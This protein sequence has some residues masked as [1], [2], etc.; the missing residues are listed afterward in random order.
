[1]ELRVLK[2]FLAVA[3][4]ESFTRAAAVLHIS[5]PTLSRQIQA[6]ED[7]L[8]K[9]LLTRTTQHLSL[10]SDGILLRKRA[11]EILALVE[12]AESEIR[13]DYEQIAG[14]IYIGG[15]ESTIFLD[16]LEVAR[17]TQEEFPFIHFHTVT[18]DC[19]MTLYDM[20]K[21]LIDF[22][23]VYGDID[24]AKYEKITLT[25]HDNWGIIMRSDDPLAAK[26]S[27]K[28]EDLYDKQLI[29][30]R[31]ALSCAAH[32]DDLRKWF[33]C[34]ME[35]LRIQ[36]SFTMLF[37]G[38]LMVKSGMGYAICFDNLMNNML[39]EDICLRPLDPPVPA[40]PNIVWRKNQVLSAAAEKFLAMLKK[41]FAK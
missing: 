7:E 27:L 6:M 16:I 33:K 22:G 13:R 41:T 11:E 30:S 4:E 20:E 23:F 24:P 40:Y 25:K 14:D 17:T 12:K 35:K 31:Q 26:K 36:N 1:M 32:S 37:N 38:A 18:C 5:Q 39:N 3:R 28:P 10:T 9:P 29:L 15:S 19:D 34:P 21:G 2:Y 8:G